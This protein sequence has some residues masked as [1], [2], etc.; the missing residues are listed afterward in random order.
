MISDTQLHKHTQSLMQRLSHSTNTGPRRSTS[1]LPAPHRL[2]LTP[3]PMPWTLALLGLQGSLLRA[4][5]G[6]SDRWRT[7]DGTQSAGLQ[8]SSGKPQWSGPAR[9]T[10]ITP[11]LSFPYP[12][13]VNSLPALPLRLGLCLSLF[14]CLSQG[15]NRVLQCLFCPP[16]R[17]TKETASLSITGPRHPDSG[18]TQVELFSLLLNKGP[19][20]RRIS[21]E[22]RM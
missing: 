13:N 8:G 5:G 9:D 4:R 12:L 15:V 7:G 11:A 10:P 21:G 18:A 17:D 1:Q 16:P 14:C 6:A 3:Q 22:S 19:Q 20:V 2:L